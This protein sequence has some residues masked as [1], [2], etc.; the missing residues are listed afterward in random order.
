MVQDAL[1]SAD[2]DAMGCAAGDIEGVDVPIL[3]VEE[4][5]SINGASGSNNSWPGTFA[6]GCETDR[7]LG[8]A[9]AMW[10]QHAVT[11]GSTTQA[12]NVPGLKLICGKCIE[13]IPGMGETAVAC[14]RSRAV[15]EQANA[16][17]LRARTRTGPEGCHDQDKEKDLPQDSTPEKRDWSASPFPVS[18][19]W[20]KQG[21]KLSPRL[22]GWRTFLV[23]NPGVQQIV[24]GADCPERR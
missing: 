10:R 4:A 3:L 23:K 5:Q 14:G 2:E 19:A 8:R 1:I 16:S 18:A 20:E 9:G 11:G 21:G 17:G 12:N 6:V 24:P 22:R 13:R 15:D 7:S